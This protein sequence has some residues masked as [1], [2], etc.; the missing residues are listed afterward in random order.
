MK[1]SGR[2][3]IQMSQTPKRRFSLRMM[4]AGER[5]L[6]SLEI[7]LVSRDSRRPAMFAVP[8]ANPKAGGL[9]KAIAV[10]SDALSCRMMKVMFDD[11]LPPASQRARDL[12]KAIAVRSDALS[13]RMMKVMFDDRLPPANQRAR[14]LMK[15]ID[16]RSDAHNSKAEM[17]KVTFA[18]RLPASQKVRGLTKAI[19][20]RSDAR[21][22]KTEMMKVTFADRLPASPKARG[23]TKAIGIRSDARSSKTEMMKVTF[24]DRLP[25][26]PK[27]RGPTKAIGI[28]SDARS[29]KTEMMKVTFADRLPA[30]LKVRGPTKVTFADRLP[31]SHK[32][33]GPTKDGNVNGT[34]CNAPEFQLYVPESPD[35]MPAAKTMQKC[36]EMLALTRHGRDVLSDVRASLARHSQ[37]SEGN[38]YPDG[39]YEDEGSARYS[40]SGRKSEGYNADGAG[41]S[42]RSTYQKSA[43]LRP[44]GGDVRASLARHSQLGEGTPYRGSRYE[45]EGSARYSLSGRKSEGYNADGAGRRD[46]RRSSRLPEG[47]EQRMLSQ[48]PASPDSSESELF[49][50]AGQ[51]G[52]QRKS[53]VIRPPER[54]VE[55]TLVLDAD[56]VDQMKSIVW[57]FTEQGA[58]VKALSKHCPK[59]TPEDIRAGDVLLFINDELVLDKE[60]HVTQMIWKDEQLENQFLTLRFRAWG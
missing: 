14:D 59:A 8:P 45:D 54:P 35:F 50:G 9:M 31:A 19:G 1:V 38:P 58:C 46:S 28:R 56:N 17:M 30:S 20:I 37:L 23:P 36:T 42:R 27:A 32:A 26:S 6:R 51:D 21:S 11:H 25:A 13:S 15:A 7:S 40:L 49:T 12:M 16:I 4:R 34:C 53:E 44:D 3:T 43:S 29:S 48:P 55:L 18:D 22:S 52:F 10:Q 24:A 47:S 41:D 57:K 2:S 60:K 5:L 39:R 33:R